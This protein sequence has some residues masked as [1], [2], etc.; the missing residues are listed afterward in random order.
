MAVSAAVIGTAFA[1]DGYVKGEEARKKVGESAAESRTA[2]AK[3]KSETE[4]QNASKQAAERRRQ[5]REDRVRRARVMQASEN[6]GTQGSSGELGALDNITTAFSGALGDSVGSKASGERMS[7]YLQD[8]ADAQFNFNQAS[9]DLSGAQ[10]QLNLGMSI[11]NSAGGFSAFK[12][13]SPTG[14][15]P[16]TDIDP[17]AGVRGQNGY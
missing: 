7:G 10:S 17:R 11:F 2:Q 13:K 12:D 15:V 3:Q 4:A 1:V 5:I 16:S 9:S 14:V 8:Q 6:T